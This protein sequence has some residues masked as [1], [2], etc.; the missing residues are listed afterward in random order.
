MGQEGGGGGSYQWCGLWGYRN[1]WDGG[2]MHVGARYYEVE[3]GRWVQ[4]D[5]V[6]NINA[7]HYVGNNPIMRIDPEGADWL[8][9]ATNFFAG[10]GD[11][12]AFGLTDRIRDWIGFN[13]VVDH[14]SGWYIGGEIAGD[15]WWIYFNGVG[16]KMGYEFAIGKNFRIAPS[17]N[18]TG[19][20]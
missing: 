18:R 19:H 9:T 2:L 14:T 10:M 13:D 20:P 7:Y 11:A 17:G 12:I 5:I 8:D 4:K 3:T 15:A 6:V 1:D 16:Y